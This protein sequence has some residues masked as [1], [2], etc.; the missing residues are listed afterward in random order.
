MFMDI[1]DFIQK[2]ELPD[3]Y[4]ISAEQWFFPVIEEIIAIRNRFEHPFVIGANGL[5]GSGKSTFGDLLCY[6]TRQKHKVNAV[7]LSIDDFYFTLDERRVLADEI[8]H[9][10]RIRGMPGTHDIDLAM[11]TL[12]QLKQFSSPVPVPRF[13]KAKNDRATEDMWDVVTRRPDII[14]LEGWCLGA[15]AQKEEEL[16][17]PVNDIEAQEDEL[18]VWRK[19]INQQLQSNYPRFFSQVD[20]WLMLKA[21]SF[22]CAFDW[23]LEQEEKLKKSLESRGIDTSGLM[24][25]KE[26]VCF[27]QLDQRIA[28]NLLNTLPEK[29]HYLYELDTDRKIINL[30]RPLKLKVPSVPE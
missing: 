10:L 2:H 22:E 18:L 12:S 13:D 27:V 11:Q 7:S 21:P 19:Y 1:S 30:T 20:I 6:V 4:A 24:T 16:E 5:P 23:R 29:V 15:T 3:D 26:L 8:H 14:V 17:Q 9:L 28:Q 25:H